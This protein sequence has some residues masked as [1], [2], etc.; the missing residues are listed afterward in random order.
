MAQM[1]DRMIDVT[2][3]FLWVLVPAFF[4]LR[5]PSIR[6]RGGKINAMTMA[7]ITM[8]FPSEVFSFTG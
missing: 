5:I 1:M 4:R 6:P 2:A 3:R 8:V 7:Q